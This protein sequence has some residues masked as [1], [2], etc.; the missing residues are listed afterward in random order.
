MNDRISC[1]K[2]ATR[3]DARTWLEGDESLSIDQDL[4]IV[5]GVMR[6][7]PKEVMLMEKKAISR[8]AQIYSPRLVS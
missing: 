1:G 2:L 8:T 4:M 3:I 6:P 7:R 5:D